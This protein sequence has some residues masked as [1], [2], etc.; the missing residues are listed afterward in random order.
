MSFLISAAYASDA[1]HHGPVP[2][3]LDPAFWVGAAFLVVV[4]VLVKAAY[5][6]I[7][8]LLDMRGIAIRDRL[9]GARRIREEAQA[10]LAEYQ[11]K[12]R[13]A[14]QESQ[15]IIARSKAEA[16]KLKDQAAQDL[17]ARVAAA[18]R[19]ALERIA[20]AEEQAKREVRNAAIEIAVAA[21]AR[22]MEEKLTAAQANSLIDRAISEIPAKMH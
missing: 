18:E 12:Q 13:D 5:G 14:L 8:R 3:Y 2:F 9:E 11:R 21:A 22:A 10:L 15:D 19:S 16:A 1:A 4:L 7:V 6:R 20:A 17:A